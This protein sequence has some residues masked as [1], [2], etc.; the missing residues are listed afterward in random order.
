MKR[1]IFSWLV[2]AL[3]TLTI[4]CSERDSSAVLPTRQDP[5]LPKKMATVF[6][7]RTILTM[8]EDNSRATAVA[9]SGDRIVAVG[10]PE[11]IRHALQDYEVQ[12]SDLFAEKVLMP[13]FIDNHLHPSLAGLLMP[14]YFI[15]P[16]AWT[17]PHQQVSGVQGRSA[18]LAR[19]REVEQSLA[20]PEEFLFTWGYHQYFHGELSRADIN[21]IS[22]TRPII[23]WHRS[24]HEIIAND[25]ALQ[26]LN[27][28]AAEFADNPAIDFERGHFWENG[29]FAIFPNLLPVVLNPERL[30]YGILEGL[31]HARQNGITTLCDQGV[32]LFDLDLEM[33]HLDAVL[34]DHALP[35]RTLLIANAKS[36]S[37]LGEEGAFQLIESLPERNTETLRYLP[38]QVKLL[39]DGAFYSQ[40]MQLQDGYLDGHHGEWIMP[41]DELLRTA[42]K[43]WM[44]DYQL[45]I[46]VNG[47]EGLRVVLDMIEKLR[48]EYPREDHQT[49]LHHY[50]YSAPE[51][52]DRV[53]NLGIQV[54]ANPY[55]LWALGDKYAEIGMGPE[56]AHAITRLGSLEQRGVPIS[57]HSD[58]PM[59]P[60]APLRLAGIAA[61]RV[62]A[63]GKVLAPGER[64][65]VETALRGIT[66]EAARAIQQQD[67]IGSIEVGKLADFTVLEQDP[68]AVPPQRLGD[69]PIWGTV[70]GGQPYPKTANRPL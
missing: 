1:L 36:L 48:A 45:H 46:H 35:L 14:A 18:Y 19:L 9:V 16:F 4:G 7:A 22:A 70:L 62:T 8:D 30:R 13:G 17:L 58:L 51:Q 3:L 6:T 34:R 28:T 67:S 60:A 2:T 42:R 5:E 26:Q 24:F 55:Y 12:Q 68:Y 65:S 64:I 63:A 38:K 43:Y 21:K 50:G 69:I 31:E 44:A 47:D 66:S 41:P 25:A 11:S 27:I 54:S 49:V 57:L 10:T 61:S 32:P 37:L 39:A 40:L 33:A 56:R 23:V 20:D 59:A 15:T 29:L 53:A 52:S